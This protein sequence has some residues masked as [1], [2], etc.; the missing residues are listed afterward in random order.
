M[1]QIIVVMLEGTAGVVG[2]VNEN[3][4][5]FPGIVRKQG[6][7]GVQIVALNEHIAGLAVAV[8]QVRRF[9]EKAIGHKSG[10]VDVV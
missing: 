8:G 5:H 2:G 3:A 6:L 1:L 4:F 10:A 9:F 7:E